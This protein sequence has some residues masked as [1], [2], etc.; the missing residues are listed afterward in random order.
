MGARR[1]LDKREIAEP[2]LEQQETWPAGD[3][4]RKARPGRVE[5]YSKAIRFEEEAGQW[6][7]AWRIDE[8]PVLVEDR[9]A[10]DA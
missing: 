4:R 1:L 10:G 7:V 6:L 8:V 3:R 2:F 5:D 9:G